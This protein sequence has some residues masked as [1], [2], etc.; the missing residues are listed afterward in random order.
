M[1]KGKHR[2]DMWTTFTPGSTKGRRVLLGADN[3]EVLFVELPT[4]RS[5]WVVEAVHEFQRSGEQDTYCHTMSGVAPLTWWQM[6]LIADEDKKKVLGHDVQRPP[7]KVYDASMG[8]PL[9]WNERKSITLWKTL[10]KRF[11]IKKVINFSPGCGMLERACLDVG[12]E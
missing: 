11:K 6:P 1:N 12:V 4:A 8:Q 2:S 9:F 3:R 7:Q 5:T 10:L